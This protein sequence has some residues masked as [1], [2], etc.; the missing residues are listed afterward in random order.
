M[1]AKGS[2]GQTLSSKHKEIAGAVYENDRIRPLPILIKPGLDY[3]EK[4]KLGPASMQ[5]RTQQQNN[6]VTN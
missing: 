1:E 4:K 5:Q 6:I 3:P 2:E